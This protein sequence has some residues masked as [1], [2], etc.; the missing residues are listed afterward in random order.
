L[1]HCILKRNR[2]VLISDSVTTDRSSNSN[3]NINSKNVQHDGAGRTG[4]GRSASVSYG[5]RLVERMVQLQKQ[6]QQ[7]QQQQRHENTSTWHH[8]QSQLNTM[9]A[10]HPN[11]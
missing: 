9:I 1:L 5:T 4:C 3:I 6:K 11:K 8:L 10:S 2:P 7:K